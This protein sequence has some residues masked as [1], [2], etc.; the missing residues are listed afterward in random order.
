MFTSMYKWFGI[1]QDKSET[2]APWK[3]K[4]RLP[5]IRYN[6]I[7]EATDALMID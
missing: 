1:E 4:K 7:N 5:S 2:A 6:F 3:P